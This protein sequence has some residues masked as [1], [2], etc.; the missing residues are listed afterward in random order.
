MDHSVT[1]E[2]KNPSTQEERLFN[3]LFE[4]VQ[5][6]MTFGSDLNQLIDQLDMS[7]LDISADVEACC[8]LFEEKVFSVLLD[9]LEETP[10]RYYLEYRLH[11]TLQINDDYFLCFCEQ[12]DWIDPNDEDVNPHLF[13][14]L[15]HT[16]RM[17]LG[18]YREFLRKWR[19]ENDDAEERATKQ[20]DKA[21]VYEREMKQL[22]FRLFPLSVFGPRLRD[23]LRKRVRQVC[24]HVEARLDR[25]PGE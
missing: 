9:G 13:W 10:F 2:F 11:W 21:Q 6:R 14:V 22:M 25:R 12:Q 8:E 20:L 3:A 7:Q 1:V 4:R 5:A 16:A 15:F 17:V 24:I 19:D 23:I 18:T